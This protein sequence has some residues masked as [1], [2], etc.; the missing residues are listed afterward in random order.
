MVKLLFFD[1]DETLIAK[2]SL[3]YNRNAIE[4]NKD[5]IHLVELE[6]GDLGKFNLITSKK[7]IELL[8][9]C[10]ENENVHW[11]IISRGG[12]ADFIPYLKNKST[13]FR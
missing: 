7:I 1:L 4:K 12:N 10:T 9:N 5:L 13:Q 3:L 8:H 11:Y 6:R 2:G